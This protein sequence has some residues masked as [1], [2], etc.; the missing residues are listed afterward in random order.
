[1]I[2]LPIADCVVSEV[3]ELLLLAVLILSVVF[4]R[5]NV[6]FGENV[7]AICVWF[8]G[9]SRLKLMALVDRQVEAT[10]LFLMM[11]MTTL[12]QLL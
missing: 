9:V 8:I 2:S 10:A 12:Q 5:V 3:T 4:G 1:M 6:P 7:E 11:V